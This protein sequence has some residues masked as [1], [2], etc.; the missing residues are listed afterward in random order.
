MGCAKKK[1]CE[2]RKKSE[3]KSLDTRQRARFA[4]CILFCSICAVVPVF[5]TGVRIKE[6]ECAFWFRRFWLKNAFSR[7]VI[8]NWEEIESLKNK[9]KSWTSPG[10]LFSHFC[11]NPVLTLYF[12]CCRWVVLSLNCFVPINTTVMLTVCYIN[13]QPGR[14]YHYSD[15]NACGESAASKKVQA[16]FSRDLTIPHL[17]LSHFALCIMGN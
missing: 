1:L 17:D 14:G 7:C 2:N 5:I 8:Q 13:R 15:T 10:I 11:T 12:A 16:T 3:W 6:I 4:N 9:K